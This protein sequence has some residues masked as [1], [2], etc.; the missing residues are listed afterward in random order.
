[1]HTPILNVDAALGSNFSGSFAELYSGAIGVFVGRLLRE[2]L[3][4]LGLW[5]I[6]MFLLSPSIKRDLLRVNS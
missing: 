2:K 5:W 1:M 6:T 4:D 3:G